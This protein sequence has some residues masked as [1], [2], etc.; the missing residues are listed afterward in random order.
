MYLPLS[1]FL[2]NRSAPILTFA[3]SNKS[4]CLD[5]NKKDASVI[6]VGSGD[7]SVSI[8]KVS[9][10]L[11]NLHPLDHVIIKQ[12]LTAKEEEQDH[13]L[14]LQPNIRVF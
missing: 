3:I 14:A 11:T 10:S 7:G 6:A 5:W 9:S 4:T 2:Q 8:L 13:E 1:N 12:F